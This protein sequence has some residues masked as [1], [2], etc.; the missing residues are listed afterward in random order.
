MSLPKL[1][2]TDNPERSAVTKLM[3]EVFNKW[4]VQH[5]ELTMAHHP[6]AHRVKETAF[7]TPDGKVIAYANLFPMDLIIGG[8]KIKTGQ[9]EFV[10]THKKYRSEGLFGKLHNKLVEYARQNDFLLLNIYGIPSYYKRFG[11]EFS[12]PIDHMSEM[13]VKD[14][15][16]LK[17]PKNYTIQKA[18]LAD[19]DQ[20]CRIYR[21]CCLKGADIYIPRDLKRF[22]VFFQYFTKPFKVDIKVVKKNRRTSGYFYT[23]FENDSNKV[24][25]AELSGL[26]TESLPLAL[27]AGAQKAIKENF[28]SFW[29]LSPGPDPVF[30]IAQLYGASE[31]TPMYRYALQT[32]ILNFEVF[33]RKLFPVL[34]KR[35][36]DSHFKG[37]SI[38]IPL[39]ISGDRSVAMIIRKGRI[40]DLKKIAFPQKAD[41]LQMGINV[42][43]KMLLGNRKISELAVTEPDFRC[44]HRLLPLAEVLFPPNKPWINYIDGP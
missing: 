16:K 13:K 22:Q 34:E 9:I 33:L 7:K 3:G 44:S 27:R 15:V 31:E 18:T 5:F 8:V 12:I 38:S 1:K 37:I 23:Y 10:A 6:G 24:F 26:N 43:A 39:V 40:S 2:F 25:L 35:I 41:R 11:Y 30:K 29:I 36:A 28:D 32:R 42:W 20:M 4:E 21:R 19:A 14:A 17:K